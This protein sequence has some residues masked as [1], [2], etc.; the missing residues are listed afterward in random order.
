MG[1][2]TMIADTNSV[3]FINFDNNIQ[4]K[5]CILIN[6]PKTISLLKG[7]KITSSSNGT[8]GRVEEEGLYLI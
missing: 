5:N 4:G 6:S 7:L 2:V 3:Y 8:E 1:E